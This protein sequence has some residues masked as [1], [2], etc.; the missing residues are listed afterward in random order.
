MQSKTEDSD[1]YWFY[2]PWA[3]ARAMRYIH[4]VGLSPAFITWNLSRWNS[5]ERNIEGSKCDGSLFCMHVV[6]PSKSYSP[7]H[8][9]GVVVGIIA[10]AIVLVCISTALADVELWMHQHTLP[11]ISQASSFMYTIAFAASFATQFIYISLIL[12]RRNQKTSRRKNKNQWIVNRRRWENKMQCVQ[13]ART[14][15]E[16]DK[17]CQCHAHCLHTFHIFVSFISTVPASWPRT[18]YSSCPC[19]MHCALFCH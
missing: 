3:T 4:F 13:Q 7:V 12:D 8:V 15:Y 18:A 9:D 2:V 17:R 14:G 16:T 5:T 10:V 19:A 6:E 11:F 1:C